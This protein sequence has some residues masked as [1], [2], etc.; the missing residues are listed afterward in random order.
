MGKKHLV[1]HL[2][3][4]GVL[5]NPLLI[6]AFDTIDRADFVRLENKTS[7]YLDEPLAIGHAQTISQPTTVAFMLE[8]LAPEPGQT[9]LDIGAGSGFQTALLAYLVSHDR[10]GQE[11]PLTDWGKVIGL[12]FVPELTRLARQNLGRY[13]FLKKGIVEIHC[14]NATRGYPKAAPFD[15]IISAASGPDI[16]KA[17]PEQL[18][19]G[20]RLVTPI[21]ES[22]ILSIKKSA[23]E[24]ETHRFEGFTFVPFVPDTEPDE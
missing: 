9:I 2:E 13:N 8:L 17:W 20:G 3:T 11:L 12:E 14:L 5:K 4:T 16:P 1:R 21:D 24:F 10:F 18:K 7:A 23:I 22:V 6:A 15:R 19:I